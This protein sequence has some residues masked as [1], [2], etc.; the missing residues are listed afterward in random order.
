MA[1]QRSK[2]G[3]EE[4]VLTWSID[5][6]TDEGLKKKISG[7]MQIQSK[8]FFH[9]A[10]FFLAESAFMKHISCQNNGG[11]PFENHTN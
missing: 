3:V 11:R 1:Q 7:C 9:I 8:L 4:I 5:I 6:S 10:L 2:T